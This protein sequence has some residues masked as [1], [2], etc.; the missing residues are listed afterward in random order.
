MDLTPEFFQKNGISYISVGNLN[1][2]LAAV[3]DN[4][5]Q[6][7]IVSI[8]N[9]QNG[10]W[11]TLELQSLRDTQAQAVQRSRPHDNLALDGGYQDEPALVQQFKSLKLSDKDTLNQVLDNSHPPALDQLEKA[12]NKLVS[13]ATAKD[14]RIFYLLV[15]NIPKS[16]WAHQYPLPGFRTPTQARTVDDHMQ[17]GGPITPSQISEMKGI[18]SVLKSSEAGYW[19]GEAAHV[20]WPDYRERCRLLIE[21]PVDIS[22]LEQNLNENK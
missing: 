17:N 10:Q 8:P 4:P 14:G 19:L 15:G 6:A 5:L 18:L 2:L 9:Q 12:K 1:S 13:L 7:S 22:L 16:D 21:H 20:L 3:P 11:L